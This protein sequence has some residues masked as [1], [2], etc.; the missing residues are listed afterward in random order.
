M[1]LVFKLD[2]AFR[3]IKHMHDIL[4]IWDALGMSFHIGFARGRSSMFFQNI[5]RR[6][7]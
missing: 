4:D 6:V 5:D 7:H 2:T 1:V 3:S